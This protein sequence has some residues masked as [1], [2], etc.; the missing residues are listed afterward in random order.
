[1]VKGWW[2]DI[3]VFCSVRETRGAAA[4]ASGRA[5]ACGRAWCEAASVVGVDVGMRRRWWLERAG[6]AARKWVTVFIF[7]FLEEKNGEF[8]EVPI[9]GWLWIV[10]S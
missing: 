3:A 4:A 1:M 7:I 8:D 9:I 10:G 5:W 2:P 6:R